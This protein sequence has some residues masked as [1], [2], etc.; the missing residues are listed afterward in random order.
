M[1]EFDLKAFRKY[2]NLTQTALSEK[3]GIPQPTLASI[4]TSRS[5]MSEEIKNKI[6]IVFTDTDFTLFE[7]DNSTVHESGG[8]YDG[9]DSRSLQMLQQALTELFTAHA[10][11]VKLLR[12]IIEVKEELSKAREELITLKK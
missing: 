6:K 12:E 5:R 3:T 1:Q 2:Y 9:R 8:R 7:I 11:N 4:E 10:E